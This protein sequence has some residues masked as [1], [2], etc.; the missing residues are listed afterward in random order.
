V[1][2]LVMGITIYVRMP[3]SEAY[4]VG[5]TSGRHSSTVLGIYFFGN[6]E[7]GGVLT[8]IMG[9]LIDHL[10]FGASFTIAG[11]AVVTVALVCSFLLAKGDD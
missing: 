10:G 8:L 3:V 7:G 6:M 11:A 2:L 4:I 1:L 9:Y 5:R